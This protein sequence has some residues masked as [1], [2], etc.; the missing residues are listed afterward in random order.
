MIMNYK[1]RT[2]I[3][4]AIGD[5]PL[6][7][8]YP[9]RVQSMTNTS[10]NDIEASV[11]QCRRIADAGADYVRLTAQGVREAD[12][13][14]EI[15]SRLR[16]EGCMVPLVADIHFNPKAAFEAAQKTD[17]VRINPGNFVDAARTFKKLTYTDEEYRQEL[18]RIHDALVPF[19]ALCREH[20]TAVRLGVNHGSLSDRIM[21]RYGDTPAG[22]VESVMEFLRVFVAENFLNVVISIKASN[23][24]VMVETVRRLV[25]AM[26][27]EDMHFP[28][29]LGV[30]EAGDGEDGR[31]KSAVGI[32]TLLAEGLG[33]TIRVSLSE[34]PEAE[35]PVARKLVDYITSRAGHKP[36]EGGF[37]KGYDP[38]CPQRRVTNKVAGVM[39][40]RMKPIVIADVAPEA[41]NGKMRP[42][43]FFAAN[44]CPDGCGNDR[45]IVPQDLYKG[46]ANESPLFTLAE[47]EALQACKAP[48]KWLVVSDDVAIEKLE[49]LRGDTATALIV[50]PTNVNVPA[51]EQAL[52]H[53][54]TDAGITLPAVI[55][56]TYSDTD[57]E[58][59]Q[60]K[61]GADFGTLLLNGFSDGIWLSAPGFADADRVVRY[62]LGILQASRLRMSKTEFISCPGCGRTL[63]DLQTTVKRVKEA[64]SHLSHLKIGIMGCI[65]NGPG[66]MA[67]ADYGYV[68]AAAGKISL[69]K[70]KECVERNIP[71]AEA[72]PRLIALIKAN[73]DWIEPEA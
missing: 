67:D 71:E 53:A 39:G 47:I 12:N 3:S 27:A 52:L 31:I 7:S 22:M 24:V 23:T 44:G 30:T 45:F 2:T 58:W 36:I 42:D 18:Q 8:D 62:E 55:K 50:E 65:V 21:S 73:G 1:R 46:C 17:K 68:G 51:G 72:I 5:T 29:H 28:L 60:V 26:D 25:R 20:H 41:L 49:P 54:L 63:Y 4:V 14:G 59:L 35:I 43:F 13:I 70:N 33:D 64:T 38:V 10:T 15:R 57:D 69:Y 40:G 48:L 34:E 61:A 9:I 6:G 32:G 37:S 66:E 11:A 19:I 56:N 16:A